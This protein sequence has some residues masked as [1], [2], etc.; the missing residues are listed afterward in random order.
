M[1][2]S[3]ADL[4]GRDFDVAVV[5]AGINGSSAAQHLAAA[6]YRVL[7]V[8]KGDFASGA[9]SRSS[10]LLHCGLRYLAPGR[11]MFDFV[12]HP[13]RLAVALRMARLAMQARAEF[14]KTSP[15]RAK[16]IR[17]H[18]P[19]YRN[20]P[21]SGW[22]VD[23]AFSI[24]NRFGDAAVPLDYE[25]I[26]PD[27]AKRTPLV[28][29]LRD[30]D[31]LASVAA[32]REYQFEWPERIALDAIADAERMGASSRNYTKA[33]MA[34]H[35]AG[36]GWSV[37]LTDMLEQTPP[38]TV[39]AKM[40]LNLAGV[41]I[42]DV[43]Q[44]ARRGAG[45]KIFG[46]K[47]AHVVVQLAPECRD[48]GIATLNSL[49]LPFYCIPWR[50]MHYFGPTETPYEGDHD[51]VTVT[52]DEVAFLLGEANRLLPSLKLTSEDG[53]MTWAGVRPLTYDEAVPFGNRSRVIHDLDAEGLPDALAMTAG[54]VMTHRSA[55]RELT[56]RVGRRVR[57][58]GPPARA[59]YA[60]SAAAS[61]DIEQATSLS[62]LLFRRR[63]VGWSGPPSPDDLDAAGA[64]LGAAL[65]WDDP[66]RAREIAGF[67][68][69]WESLYGSRTTTGKAGR[70][71]TAS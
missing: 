27:E 45:R 21:Y 58:S 16:P 60:A 32:F 20:G 29:G 56:E 28:S 52:A 22:Q 14:V 44:D 62:D 4:E 25:R 55:G 13:S 68:A 6:G 33:R 51:R 39:R 53:I 8:D 7:L 43:L 71:H 19:I 12:R 2:S 15:E 40:V 18:F 10:R 23:L 70:R 3:L 5:G 36:Q 11:S 17:L 9:S 65:G 37:E 54:P 26:G 67:L 59:N 47:G 48:L 30:M 41:W 49:G 34:S 64:E 66:R 50:G 31:D 1:R 69:E 35:E 61:S 57:P 38:V 42:D 24:L 46:T 63:G